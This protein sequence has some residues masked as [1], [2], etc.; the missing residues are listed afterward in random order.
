MGWNAEGSFASQNLVL[1][2]ANA[3]ITGTLARMEV[4]VDGMKE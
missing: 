3:K 2:A 4:W 1:Y